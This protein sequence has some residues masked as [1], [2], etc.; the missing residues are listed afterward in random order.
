[1][2]CYC[3]NTNPNVA[4]FLFP[5]KS[6]M[7]IFPLVIFLISPSHSR[8]VLPK[9]IH[10]LQVKQSFWLLAIIPIRTFRY[11]G[12]QKLGMFILNPSVLQLSCKNEPSIR[13]NQFSLPTDVFLKT[14][15]AITLK[16]E[17]AWWLITIHFVSSLTFIPRHILSNGVFQYEASFVCFSVKPSSPSSTA[18]VSLLVQ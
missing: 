13:D 7:N 9:P 6:Q 16:S 2:Q 5:Q 3:T 4:V 8:I 12:S 15:S 17:L 18:W 10:E 1:M 14:P 11:A